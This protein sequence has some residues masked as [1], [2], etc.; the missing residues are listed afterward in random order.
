MHYYGLWTHFFHISSGSHSLF[1]ILIIYVGKLNSLMCAFAI[2]HWRLYAA[3]DS[4]I[5]SLH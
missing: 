3:N 2:L 1:L 4:I 5:T